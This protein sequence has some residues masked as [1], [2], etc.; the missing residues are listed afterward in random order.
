MPGVG[1]E[2]NSDDTYRIVPMIKINSLFLYLFGFRTGY[3]YDIK[4]DKSV[5]RAGLSL[6]VMILGVTWDWDY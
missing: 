5:Y 3:I 2:T 6:D 4:R 1:I